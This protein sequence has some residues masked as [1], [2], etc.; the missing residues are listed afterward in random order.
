MIKKIGFVVD[1]YTTRNKIGF[2]SIIGQNNNKRYIASLYNEETKV[3]KR[4]ISESETSIIEDIK[5]YIE[6]YIGTITH[7][8]PIVQDTLLAAMIK[9]LK[10]E[11]EED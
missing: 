8:F 3:E 1:E 11:A 5:A 9:K 2:Y 10:G 7:E 6:D 4:F